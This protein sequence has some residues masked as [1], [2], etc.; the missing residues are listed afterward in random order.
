MLLLLLQNKE[1]EETHK[2][3]TQEKPKSK[4]KDP[5]KKHSHS[6]LRRFSSM[7]HLL[8]GSS[9]KDNS[10]KVEDIA[11]KRHPSNA[12]T[13]SVS[14]T[15]MDDVIDSSWEIVEEE[16]DYSCNATYLCSTVIN[17]P[18]RPKHLRECVKQY[19][20]QQ[21][22]SLKKFGMAKSSNEVVLN[23]T[24]EGVKMTNVT[25]RGGQ[26][27]FFPIDSVSHVMAHP[28]NAEYFAFSTIVTGDSKHKCHLFEQTKIPPT[29]LIER[30]QAFM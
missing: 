9:K 12:R 22:K 25:E 20:K 11:D 8:R 1:H 6:K 2:D 18:L 27:M 14:S 10:Q 30:F 29:E 23:L 7:P 26:G 5:A 16:M 28:E 19:Q 17:P 3:V 24:L 13:V 4:G 21:T 15:G